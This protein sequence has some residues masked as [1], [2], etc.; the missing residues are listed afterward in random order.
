MDMFG[1]YLF[2]L[3]LT[4]TIE[5]GVAYL[6]GF[7]KRQYQLAFAVIN[8]ITNLS[9]NYLILVLGYLSIRVTFMFI[10]TLEILVVVVEWQLLIYIF[11]DSKGRFLVLSILANAAS[12]FAGLLLFWT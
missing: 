3:L 9:L 2:A 6:L 7:R 1:R 10:V 12:F 4:I 8:T 5:G 11:R